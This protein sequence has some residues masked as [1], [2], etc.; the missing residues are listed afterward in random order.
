V[1]RGGPAFRDAFLVGAPRNKVP[2]GPPALGVVGGLWGGRLL[3][4]LTGWLGL[5]EDDRMGELGE[6][7]PLVVRLQFLRTRDSDDPFAFHF[8]PQDYVVPSEGGGSPRAHFEWSA[9]DRADLQ[10]VRRPGRDPAVVQRLGERLRR[11]L[12]SAGLGALEAQ[13][14]EAVASERPIRIG[15]R[16]SAAELYSLPWEL[17]TLASG[18]FVGEL[19][20]LLLRF[21]WPETTTTPEQ[22]QPRGEGGRILVAW[23]AAGG[24][25]PAEEHVGAIAAACR[26]GAH[27]FERGRDVLPSASLAGIVAALRE[28]Q[29]GG[30]PVAVLHLLCHGAPSGSSFGL[31]LDGRDGPAV[32][33]PLALRQ[34]APF[35][36]MVRLVVLSACESGDAGAPGSQLGSVAQTL[37]RCGFAAVVAS[38]SPLSVLGSN[39]LTQVFYR[40]LLVTP[41][42]V[43]SAL[44]ATRS[45]LRSVEAGQ[46]ES[47]QSLDWAS[48]QLYARAADGQDS[49][50]IVI[51]PYRGLL[52][53]GPEH[54]RFFFGRDREVQG[55][56]ADL[57]A[58]IEAGR[59][60]FLL[61]CGASGTGKSSLAL[62]GV[63]PVLLSADRELVFLRMRPGSDP[64][65][66]LAQAM[67]GL[68]DGRRGLLVVDQLEEIFTQT[69]AAGVR[70]TFLQKLWVLASAPEPG[71]RVL[72][73]L[74]VDF[75]GR[76][77]EIVLDASGLRLDRVAYDE[78]HRTFV[79]QMAPE[80]LRAA[81]V[82]PA[83]KVGLELSAGLAERML[84]EVDA[85]PGAL[86][87]LQDALDMLWQR[88]QGNRLSQ[89]VYDEL[90]GVVGT[91]R[92]RA[93]AAL[94]QLMARGEQAVAK[95][96][97][98]SLVA[99]A[100]DSGLDTRARLRRSDL[101]ASF[102]AEDMP[103]AERVLQELVAARLLVLDGDGEGVTVEVAHE[104][105]IRKWPMLRGWLDEGRAG[106]IHKRRIAAAAREWERSGRD[107]SLLYR[108]TQLTLALS[109]QQTW[110]AQGRELEHSFILAAQELQR[111]QE[112][113]A[114]DSLARE[115]EAAARTLKLLLDSYVE[116]GHH[117]LWSSEDAEEPLKWLFL[118]Y[119][120]GSQHPALPYLLRTAMRPI[121]GRRSARRCGQPV[122]YAAFTSD[123]EEV[124]LAGPEALLARCSGESDPRSLPLGT[125]ILFV[126]FSSDGE[127][128][129]VR[130]M[131][132]SSVLYHLTRNRIERDLGPVDFCFAAFSA[133][134]RQLVT[135]N[136]DGRV[137]ILDCD[138]GQI[139][140]EPARDRAPGRIVAVS[141]DGRY[142][143][144]LVRQA[145]PP[146]EALQIFDL[147][148]QVA[149]APLAVGIS[150][151]EFAE[152]SRDGQRL[153]LTLSVVGA[154]TKEARVFDNRESR[155]SAGPAAG[156][157]PPKRRENRQLCVIPG[158]ISPAGQYVRLS[159]DGCMVAALCGA[160]T[161]GIYD[162]R[163]GRLLMRLAGHRA[164]LLFLAFD[165][166]SR[167]VVTCCDFGMLRIFALSPLPVRVAS[168]AGDTVPH[169]R[170]SE[171]AD[172]R[173]RI[174]PAKGNA[175]WISD[176][177][178]GTWLRELLGHRGGVPWTCLSPDGRCLATSGWEGT[179]RLWDTTTWQ[180]RG[181]LSSHPGPV[182]QAQ[183]RADGQQ[184]LTRGDDGTL[185]IFDVESGYLLTKLALPGRVIGEAA[186]TS[187]GQSLLIRDAD[188]S[189]YLFDVRPESRSIADLQAAI[190]ARAP[191]LLPTIAGL[192]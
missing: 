38:R 46:A 135:L 143:L 43:E 10:A 86:P 140:A 93:D 23:S 95:R 109:W 165:A 105:L 161:A 71:L 13:I 162:A 153:L 149:H 25:V 182:R 76:C 61:L 157:A 138:S 190:T 80:Q 147:R 142:G 37:H 113:E 170:A 115:R 119:Q 126:T 111:R 14:Q 124:L 87:L 110:G 54:G 100:E 19:D 94:D 4:A 21:E 159:P 178:S 56:V 181:V 33:S 117:L 30:A 163:D 42:S 104:A 144:C 172:G 67:A 156:G 175:V 151:L 128:V 164:P 136:E 69:Q 59:P 39:T 41:D 12:L 65:S 68:P 177:A 141:P 132:A 150:Y 168:Y 125:G 70:S 75:I 36:K 96:L 188:G 130:R 183:F 29:Q 79:A 49:R 180:L 57:N 85:E 89:A 189:Q 171:T 118:A 154:G 62:A 121:D 40:K 97:L 101:L 8:E 60:R 134:G 32:V 106:L 50:P 81:I 102:T 160:E 155:D 78:A 192:E 114:A 83:R 20:G 35:A 26:E 15:I 185:C 187:D 133:D 16:S 120:R 137:R 18:Q 3:G 53:F 34:L 45:E 184:L 99:V 122:P 179:T 166:G 174:E 107:E 152:F 28:A 88:R 169:K 123:G 98:I 5:L 66:A 55:A 82:E 90:G 191:G 77:G 127:R 158:L 24:A 74:R 131:A 176:A 112:Q 9:E 2:G 139:L 103:V 44:L 6:G 72:L 48:L 52:A 11:F 173:F 1:N 129:F 47:E 116:R 31:C 63:V 22:P 64:L 145:A 17:L 27:P 108:G 92:G 91:L 167:Q 186:F 73:T 51:R 146:G 84:A 58:L 7:L 148:L